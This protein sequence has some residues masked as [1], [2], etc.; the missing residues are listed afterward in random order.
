MNKH[1]LNTSCKG[2]YDYLFI[3]IQ[4]RIRKEALSF[5]ILSCVENVDK[6]QC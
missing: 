5:Y 1:L 6:Q 4:M 2:N 3:D